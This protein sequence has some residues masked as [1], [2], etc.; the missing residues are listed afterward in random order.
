MP[1]ILRSGNS[2]ITFDNEIARVSGLSPIDASGG[3][4]TTDGSTTYHT[5]LEDGDFRIFDMDPSMKIN[6]LVVGAGSGAN[7]GQL[8]MEGGISGGGGGEVVEILDIQAEVKTYPVIVGLG[9]AGGAG[10]TLPANIAYCGYAGGKSWFDDI[11]ASG[12]LNVGNYLISSLQNIYGRNGKP[13]GSGF[14]GGNYVGTSV[15]GYLGGGGGGD[16]SAGINPQFATG[17][18]SYLPLILGVGGGGTLSEITGNYY[19]GGGGGY[20]NSVNNPAVGGIGGGGRGAYIS[21]GS[22]YNGAQGGEANTG[23]GAGGGATR[24]SLSGN[25]A[26]GGSG[27]VVVS[28][29]I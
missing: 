10:P 13:S 11:D 16:S 19:G 2:I 24:N 5:F 8:N 12:G 18:P 23:G 25:G 21:G 17:F 3:I 22:Y 4:I 27:I 6:V 1:Y 20:S 28:Y 14:E 15:T 26:P 29:T 9:G 7:G